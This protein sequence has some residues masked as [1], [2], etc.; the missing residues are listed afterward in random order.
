M[1]L[2]D[3]T[4]AKVLPAHLFLLLAGAP[5]K[6]LGCFISGAHEFKSRGILE[7]EVF[8]E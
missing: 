2:D 1:D 6:N 4:A 5:E 3:Y 7:Y 8:K